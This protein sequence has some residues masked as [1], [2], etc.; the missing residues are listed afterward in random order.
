MMRMTAKIHS[1]RARLEE[2]GAKM[3]GIWT[4]IEAAR[5][6]RGPVAACFVDDDIAAEAIVEA[7]VAA[8]GPQYA[9]YL[10]GLTPLQV[11]KLVSPYATLAAWRM[12]QGIYRFDPA[13]Y[14]P[15]IT[16]PLAGDL[17]ADILLRLPAWCVYLETPGLA[18][19]RRDGSG[20]ALLRGAWA[21]LNVEPDKS[22]SL[23]V[24]LDIEGDAEFTHQHLPLSGSLDSSIDTVLRTWAVTDPG[25]KPAIAGYL[26]PIV[27]LLLYLC[28]DG[29]EVAGDGPQGNPAPKRTRRG[30]WKIFP[31]EGVRTWDVGVRLG[32]ALRQAYHA[33]ETG[34]AREEG[35]A[36][37]RAHVR[38]AHWH[39][40]RAGPM[41]APDGSA[42]PAAARDFR[43][44]WLPPIP[45][46]VGDVDELPATVRQV[47][48][49]K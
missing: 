27:N 5:Q 11:A 34:Q 28:S 13:L 10:R 18:V 9:A 41:K 32:V 1:A 36:A 19:P 48:A 15:L 31:A 3:P 17:P 37:P 7:G 6:K 47:R 21:R 2:L 25:A 16:T 46:N 12:T 26:G 29:A 14:Q 23:V 35:R 42:I 44:K 40:F 30:G 8:H 4:A 20:N 45:V 49:A 22:F 33:A 39:G 38:R 43:V 24:G